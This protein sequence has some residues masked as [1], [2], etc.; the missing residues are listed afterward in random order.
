MLHILHTA[1]VACARPIPR[2]ES[3]CSFRSLSQNTFHTTHTSAR[4]YLS[5]LLALEKRLCVL[6]FKREFV[7]VTASFFPEKSAFGLRSVVPNDAVASIVPVPPITCNMLY[8]PAVTEFKAPHS[9]STVAFIYCTLAQL[10]PNLLW[11]LKCH[12]AIY[13]ICTSPRN[14]SF[15]SHYCTEHASERGLHLL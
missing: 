6:Y 14:C 10:T 9:I 1:I 7:E 3:S 8:V 2:S 4:S 13:C 11:I 12:S 15:P 5:F